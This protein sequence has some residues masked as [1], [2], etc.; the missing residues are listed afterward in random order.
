M[1]V[2]C[3]CHVI[4][5]AYN[6]I[7]I[8]FAVSVKKTCARFDLQVALSDLSCVYCFHFNYKDKYFRTWAGKS[9]NA[10]LFKA[11]PQLYISYTYI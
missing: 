5:T 8:A 11:Q 6:A 10:A 7:L 3:D 2:V 9:G 1:I 4:T